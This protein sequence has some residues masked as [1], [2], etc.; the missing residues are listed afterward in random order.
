MA[1]C[2]LGRS[3]PLKQ[4]MSNQRHLYRY[5]VVIWCVVLIVVYQRVPYYAFLLGLIRFVSH[6]SG[7][8]LNTRCWEFVWLPVQ[9]CGRCGDIRSP[10][11]FYIISAYTVDYIVCF[12]AVGGFGY[13]RQYFIQSA[14]SGY[15]ATRYFCVSIFM[16]LCFKCCYDSIA[17]RVVLL[18][19]TRSCCYQQMNGSP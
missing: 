1:R 5:T 10:T 2:S 7:L 9:N 17:S 3:S 6:N 11:L 4:W 8:Q 13:A 19:Q 12:P 18:C 16:I 15:A 14:F